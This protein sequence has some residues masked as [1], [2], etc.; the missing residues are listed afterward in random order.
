MHECPNCHRETPDGNFCVR[1]GEPQ[2]RTPSAA[3]ARSRSEFAAA[4][5]QREWAPW[6]VSTLFPQLPRH[7]DRRFRVALLAGAVLVVAL[8]AFRLYPVAVMV[9]ALL[10]PLL[11]VIYF[12]DVDVYEQSPAWAFGWT[13][14]WGAAAGVGVGFLARALY[15]SGFALIDRGSSQ[16]LIRGGVVVPA[17]GVV[18][19]L[20]GPIALLRYRMFSETRGGAGLGGATAAAFSAGLAVV[21]GAG[22]LSSGLR[23]AGAQLPWVERLVALRIATP[24]LSMAG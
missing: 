16:L 17:I 8:A 14:V 9:A 20:I 1:C 6:L 13:L 23:P 18:V 22:S 19:M 12:Y 11:T 7:S 24:G 3:G 15:P 5:G 21:A 10:M 2:D 4:P